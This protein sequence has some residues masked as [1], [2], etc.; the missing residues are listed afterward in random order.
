MIPVGSF[1]VAAR[2][3][4]AQGFTFYDDDGTSLEYLEGV[5]TILNIYWNDNDKLLIIKPL[6]D[7][8]STEKVKRTFRVELMSEGAVKTIKYKGKEVRLRFQ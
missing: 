1:P 3:G 6:N 4:F 7:K 8:K 5:Y 2:F